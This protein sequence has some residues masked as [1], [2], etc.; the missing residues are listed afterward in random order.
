M[1]DFA[2]IIDSLII[3]FENATLYDSKTASLLLF[4]LYSREKENRV[5]RLNG[6]TH[7]EL[8]R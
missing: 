2:K 5:M 6:K 7:K 4:L 8:E 1:S 3:S